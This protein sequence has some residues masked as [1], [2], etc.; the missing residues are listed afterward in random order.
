MENWYKVKEI[1][2]NIYM[3][4]ENGDNTMYLLCGVKKALLIDTG[5]GI[6]DL[7]AVIRNI[8]DL[9]LI[10]VNTHGHPDHVSGD[11][12]FDKVHIGEK[13]ISILEGCLSV[14]NRKW[15]LN[16]V[17]R[18]PY[19]KDFNKES[20]INSTM[21]N[22]ISISEGDTFDLGNKIIEVIEIPGHTPGSIGLL[23][24]HS[25]VL[26]SGDSIMHGHIWL[27]TEQST[28]LSMYHEGLNRLNELKGEFDIILPSHGP[29]MKSDVLDKFILATA[30]IIKNELV[31]TR[32]ETFVGEGLKL[33]FSDFTLIYNP[34]KL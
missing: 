16:T 21:D 31:G 30:G 34:S 32:H 26:F 25:K 8:T 4:D 2:S 15:A 29:T 27:H 12:L 7:R 19:P 11:F 14:E 22:I 3:I 17:Q 6:H 10:V 9:P 28:K 33:D 1:K 5:W 20:W 24:R 23:D 13:D 18:G